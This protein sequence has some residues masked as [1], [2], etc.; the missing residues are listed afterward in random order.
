M[1]VRLSVG[2][3]LFFFNARE[4]P[5]QNFIIFMKIIF[6][7]TTCIEV[8]SSN[9]SEKENTSDKISSG[10]QIPGTVVT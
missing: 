1:V 3:G 10:A 6:H 9:S 7:S 5:S 4:F 2:M 8:L